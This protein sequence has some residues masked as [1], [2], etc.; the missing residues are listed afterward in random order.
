MNAVESCEA[1][2][3]WI[4]RPS[5]A[6]AIWPIHCSPAALLA[7]G[8]PF[9]AELRLVFDDEIKNW[10]LE[11]DFG[12][13]K[14]PASTGEIVDFGDQQ[15]LGPCPK[16]GHHSSISAR[17]RLNHFLDPQPRVEIGADLQAADPLK[18]KDTKTYAKRRVAIGADTVE[19]IRSYRLRQ[20]QAVLAVGASLPP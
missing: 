13:D 4:T 10:K 16:C 7:A 19:V 12:E 18:F 3:P 2:P 6:T 14:D 20:V 11:F 15:P 9:S 8:W 1:G 5:G 17:Q